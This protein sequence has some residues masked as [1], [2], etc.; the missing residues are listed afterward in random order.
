MFNKRLYKF[1]VVKEQRRRI[2]LRSVGALFPYFLLFAIN[3]RQASIRM[4]SFTLKINQKVL[5]TFT[6]D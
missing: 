5:S 3:N 1:L 2:L 4:K 6:I